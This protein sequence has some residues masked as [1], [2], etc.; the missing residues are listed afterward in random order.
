MVSNA[1]GEETLTGGSLSRFFLYVASRGSTIGQ[2]LRRTLVRCYRYLTLT[3]IFISTH[4]AAAIYT[5]I[6]K[7]IHRNTQ[8]SG[9]VNYTIKDLGN[10][11]PAKAKPN[12]RH[13]KQRRRNG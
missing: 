9:P 12:V 4:A 6:E 11:L 10:T 1:V 2:P 5:S 7:N 13:I 8:V 3:S